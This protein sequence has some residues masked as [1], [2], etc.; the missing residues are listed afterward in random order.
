VVAVT[1]DGTNDAPALKA[2]HVGLSMGI[3]GTEVA[4]EA[5]KIIILDD[6]FASIVATVKWGRSVFKNISSFLSFQLAINVS[7]LTITFIIACTNDGSTQSFPITPTQLIYV[8]L[9]MDSLG[10]LMLATSPPEERMMLQ[11]PNSKDKPLLTKILLKMILAHGVWETIVILVLALTEFGKN[12]LLVPDEFAI[13]TREHNTAVFNTFIFLVI[14]NKLHAAKIHDELDNVFTEL[15]VNM[16]ALGILTGIVVLQILI[17]EVGGQVFQT[18]PQNWDQWLVAIA[19]GFTSIPLGYLVKLIP[20]YDDY[21]VLAKTYGF[22]AEAGAA[23]K[24]DQ[25][26]ETAHVDRSKSGHLHAGPH[27]T[28][29]HTPSAN[30]MHLDNAGGAS[31]AA[32]ASFQNEA[33]ATMV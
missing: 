27:A 25:R 22:H 23:E 20:F 33:E 21:D 6:N 17:V 18:V 24:A 3:T 7:A 19:L 26:L 4:K 8:N 11:V 13:G 2:A 9:I 12:V 30:P 32:S 29:I 1:G 10:A 31:A 5:S 28:H 16:L 15:T 14:W